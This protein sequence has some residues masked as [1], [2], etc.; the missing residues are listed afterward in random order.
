M[1]LVEGRVSVLG[2]TGR[3][4]P[5]RMDDRGIAG[6]LQPEAA[7]LIAGRGNGERRKKR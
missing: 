2:R 4:I 7:S 6:V 1:T 5:G 3:R